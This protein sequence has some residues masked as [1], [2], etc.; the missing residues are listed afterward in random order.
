MMW[1]RKILVIRIPTEEK[2]QREICVLRKLCEKLERNAR[3]VTIP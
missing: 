3:P 2:S 1:A